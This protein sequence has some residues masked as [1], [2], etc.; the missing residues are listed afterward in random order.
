[1]FQELIQLIKLHLLSRHHSQE[2]PTTY[3]SSN[4]IIKNIIFVE[5]DQKRGECIDLKR[6]IVACTW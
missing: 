1:M 5:N 2:M 6:L 4:V 3:S